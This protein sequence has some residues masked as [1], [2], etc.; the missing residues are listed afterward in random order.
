MSFKA[1]SMRPPRREPPTSLSTLSG[2]ARAPDEK[3]NITASDIS[4]MSEAVF[5]R[6]RQHL[7][8]TGAN[9]ERLLRDL[10]NDIGQFGDE[11]IKKRR[12]VVLKGVR[13]PVDDGRQ[14]EAR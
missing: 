12:R 7:P 8:A 9:V 3:G 1:V 4:E 14:T 5:D 10:Q 11:R 6:F 2:T 13:R